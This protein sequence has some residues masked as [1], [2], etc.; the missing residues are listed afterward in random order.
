MSDSEKR[1]LIHFTIDGKQYTTRD[2][3]QEAA[4]L[5]RLAGIDP[6]QYD[7][8][9]RKKDGETKTIKDDKIVEIKDGD[10]FF[11]VRQNA[12]VG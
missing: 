2:D 7:L 11:T 8:A 12:T 4:S 9:R 10:V 3:D 5:L 1:K 6:I